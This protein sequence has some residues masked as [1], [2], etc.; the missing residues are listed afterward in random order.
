[1]SCS[2]R[3]L[4]DGS[5]VAVAAADVEAAGVVAV[6]G[7]A[8]EVPAFVS[9]VLSEL[10][11]STSMASDPAVAASAASDVEEDSFFSGS[12]TSCTVGILL[13]AANLDFFMD[14]KA[15]SLS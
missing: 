4:N 5:L 2:L 7:G 9:V 3:L 10:S 14:C 11:V 12:L 13:L 6:V 1:M 8:V 15:A